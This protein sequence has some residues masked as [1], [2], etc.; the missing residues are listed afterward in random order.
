VS[1][2][3]NSNTKY[4]LTQNFGSL[5]ILSEFLER[6][7]HSEYRFSETRYRERR[8]A[9]RANLQKKPILKEEFVAETVT[10]FYMEERGYPFR[11]TRVIVIGLCHTLCWIGSSVNKSQLHQAGLDHSR[12]ATSASCQR[13]LVLRSWNLHLTS[14]SAPWQQW[15]MAR[16][17][18][19]LKKRNILAHCIP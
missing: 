4:V 18:S 9:H 1:A 3:T 11:L 14:W 10:F 5:L 8:G 16:R 19:Y 17:V 15:R 6:P 2:G 12:P 7:F 13:R